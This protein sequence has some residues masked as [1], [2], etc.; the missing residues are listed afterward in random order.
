MNLWARISPILESDL[1]AADRMVLVVLAHHAHRETAECRLSV[2][3]IA[4]EAGITSRGAQKLLARLEGQ[5]WLRRSQRGA[6][7]RK[8]TSVYRLYPH[9]VPAGIGNGVPYSPQQQ[10]DGI[11]NGVPRIGNHVPENREPRSDRTYSE[12]VKN[13][14]QDGGHAPKGAPPPARRPDPKATRRAPPVVTDEEARRR[15]EKLRVELPH[16]QPGD[17]ARAAGLPLDHVH[18]ILAR[19]CA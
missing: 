17:I 19:Q 18:S 5:G 6:M 7:G 15:V 10:E 2:A 1:P 11:G 14:A 16:L 8:A 13:R 12:P 4:R 3:T 9:G